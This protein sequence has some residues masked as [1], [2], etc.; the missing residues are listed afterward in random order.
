M[1]FKERNVGLEVAFR[2]FMNGWN[3]SLELTCLS[4]YGKYQ[5]ICLGFVVLEESTYSCGSSKEKN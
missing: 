5:A 3:G 2:G 4:F 1:N